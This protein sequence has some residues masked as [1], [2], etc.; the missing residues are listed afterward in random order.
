[1]M[2]GLRSAKR[3]E[4]DI[5]VIFDISADG[6]VSVSAVDVQTGLRQTITVTA[7]SG[8]TED[9]IKSAT[10]ANEEWMLGQKEDPEF[11]KNKSRAEEIFKQFDELWPRLK[12]A[13]ANGLGQDPIQRA[14]AA[15]SV[16]KV[17]VQQKDGANLGAT[18][19]RL[20]RMLGAL[21]GAV[22]RGLVPPGGRG[23]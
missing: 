8:L 11:Q 19:D 4:V 23:T 16:A 12:Q 7:S 14:E 20:E 22:E 21:R 5:D 13:A 1:M 6:I 18:V 9:E 15:L 17:Q 3:G 2:T 10:A